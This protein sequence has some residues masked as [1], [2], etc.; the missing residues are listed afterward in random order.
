[1]ICLGEHVRVVVRV[2]GGDY[3]KVKRFE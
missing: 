3:F 1:V 2:A